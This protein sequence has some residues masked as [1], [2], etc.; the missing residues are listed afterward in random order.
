MWT[1]ATYG[2]NDRA[3]PF[4]KGVEGPVELLL[5]QTNRRTTGSRSACCTSSTGPTCSGGGRGRRARIRGRDRDRRYVVR[6]EAPGRLHARA[7]LSPGRGPRETHRAWIADHYTDQGRFDQAEAARGV[8]GGPYATPPDIPRPTSTSYVRAVG[9]RRATWTTM[10]RQAKQATSSRAVAILLPPRDARAHRR[11][12]RLP[13]RNSSP[14]AW[15]SAY[16]QRAKVRR[17]D[18]R[19]V[20]GGRG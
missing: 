3:R 6:D 14:W 1:R 7:Y 10:L 12:S 8:D 20:R 2:R 15:T 11:G 4:R 13:G 18:P 17:T 19:P 5:L 9:E 16:R